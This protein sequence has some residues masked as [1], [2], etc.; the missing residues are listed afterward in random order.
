MHGPFGVQALAC[1]AQSSLKAELQTCARHDAKFDQFVNLA[2]RK[3]TWLRHCFT[4]RRAGGTAFSCRYLPTL[5]LRAAF[6]GGGE[7][8]S[9]VVRK[10]CE[11]FLRAD[12]LTEG[13]PN[14]FWLVTIA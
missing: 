10:M 9:S 7:P 8:E 6:I 3:R 5:P 13:T 4:I 12:P 14:V 1:P 2:V 11:S